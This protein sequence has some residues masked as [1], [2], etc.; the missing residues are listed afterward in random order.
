MDGVAWLFG[1]RERAHIRL[2][3]FVNLVTQVGLNLLVSVWY[4]FEGQLSALLLLI[5]AELVVL[6]VELI[7]Y[8]R[9]L[10]TEN[11]GAGW[12]ALYTIAANLASVYIGWHLI[13]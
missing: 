11:R 9:R 12:A 5:L 3:L 7:F 10:R 4:F 6:A 1:Y 2:I 8:C 13:D